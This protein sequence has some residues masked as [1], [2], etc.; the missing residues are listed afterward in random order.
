MY[1][2][3]L[4]SLLIILSSFQIALSNEISTATNF[5]Q[6]PFDVLKYDVDIQI[7]E[8]ATRQVKGNCQMLI[9][10][11]KQSAEDNFYFHLFELQID[12]AKV[13]TE[14]I[15]PS[16]H[17][18]ELGVPY[19]SIP[20]SN[21]DS[22]L[23][24]L[25]VFYSGTMSNEG[26]EMQWG[27]INYLDGA[28]F[29][30]GVGFHNA[31]VSAAAYWFPCYDHPSDKALYQ[32]QVTVPSEYSVALSGMPSEIETIDNNMHK[33]T[34]IGEVPAATYMIGIAIGKYEKLTNQAGDTP[35]EIYSPSQQ[36]TD[37]ENGLKL[38]PK[39]LECFEST[40]GAYP[41]EKIG[42]VLTAIGSME[43]QG[44]IA[45]AKA[46]VSQTDTISSTAAHELSH[47]WFGGYVTPL[48]F[49]SA[50]LNESF[51]T[52]SEAIWVGYLLGDLYYYR[53][54]RNLA[55]VYHSRSVSEGIFPLHDFIR[56][57]NSSNY[58]I[59]I[60]NKGALV[61][62]Q[63]RLELGDS[64]FF[65]AIREYLADNSN[66][67]ATT[68]SFKQSIE[69][70][71]GKDLTEFFNSWVYGSGYPI[72]DC[73]LEQYNYP[74]SKFMKFKLTTTQTQ[75]SSWG[76]YKNLPL[77]INFKLM[78]DSYLNKVIRINEREQTVEIDSIPSYKT[79]D[80]N[81]GRIAASLIR[82]ASKSVSSVNSDECLANA[83]Q[84]I[85]N[86]IIN[87]KLNFRVSQPLTGDVRVAIVDL[88]GCTLNNFYYSEL[89]ANANYELD[90]ANLPAG[91]YLLQ[92]I[93]NGIEISSEC[94]RVIR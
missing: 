91:A 50:W 74:D 71:T 52:Y 44:M 26:G 9:K 59:T 69:S 34:A 49:R 12:S 73:K 83:L 35:I 32:V 30:M 42:Y 66:A 90:I 36:V 60:Y 77:E 27:G 4:F 33:T 88:S 47:S 22:E 28:L 40:W 10:L 72:V 14:L 76:I 2:N 53:K 80:Y 92:I 55:Y 75:N 94:F 81:L 61:V 37:C 89:Q 5:R 6:Q 21:Y 58:P 8:P 19:Y 16:Q 17:N 46:A 1:K 15:N 56:T 29:N 51:A 20:I 65:A 13:G 67:N 3:I 39:M 93:Q 79:I 85:G 54:L 78:D 64:L 23:I 48:D 11:A 57:G 45:L 31:N 18:D 84:I 25:T 43:H 82:V 7:D 87:S 62:H 24:T 68:E 41:F 63:L 70:T 38:V 86:P